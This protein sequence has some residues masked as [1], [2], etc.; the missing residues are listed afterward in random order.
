M[1][2]VLVLTGG[3]GRVEAQNQCSISLQRLVDRASAGETVEVP[4]CV[5]REQVVVDEPIT[6]DAAP[7]AEIRGSRIWKSWTRSGPRWTSAAAVPEFYT[8]GECRE[9]TRRCLWAE[10]VFVDG[11]ALLQVAADPGPGQFA[12]D[13]S[14]R[15]VLGEN[16][17][18]RTVEVTVRDAWIEARAD[19]VTVKG[20]R[21]RHAANDAQTGGID[22]DGHSGWT[23]R[24]NVLSEA[25]GAVVSLSD[26][27]GNRLLRNNIFRGGQQGVHGNGTGAVVRGNQIHH[28][29]TE[30]FSAGWEAGGL[31]MALAENVTLTGNSV[32]RNDGP[33]LWCDIDC[34]NVTYTN[35]RV[36]HNQNAGIFFEISDGAE[37]SGNK[38]YENG[39]GFPDW[40]WGAG[41]LVSSSRNADV[42]DNTVAWNADG[43]TVLS[44][45]RPA[46]FGRD[47][48]RWNKVSG[49]AVHDNA[50]FRAPVSC[51][52]YWD[53]LGLGWLQD[54]DGTMYEPAS[55]NRGAR[56]RYWYPTA[57]GDGNRFEFGDRG[58]ESLR[59]FNATPGEEDGRY[60]TNR[61]KTQILSA[62]GVP[63]TPEPR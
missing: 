37:I 41:I 29:N 55:N 1:V 3:Q 21:M 27:K 7:G 63:T 30:A 35:N 50:I 17:A 31:K 20:F 10:Q 2:L 52:D 40:G 60:L 23:I 32:Y 44:Q 48:A 6:L 15:V 11:T 9:G 13:G 53:H 38:V 51:C 61:E 62:A 8:H 47:R 19:G 25:H 18:G 24:D 16:P 45:D 14:R 54:W 56:N 33:G 39:W 49:N 59:D 4:A 58:Y 42:H 12:V 34:K 57:E 46:D 26:G 36:H 22:L 28:N 5:Y 43:V